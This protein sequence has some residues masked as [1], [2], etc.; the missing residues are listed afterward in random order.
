MTL[1]VKNDEVLWV[2]R[3]RPLKI[4]DTILPEQTKTIF[5]KFVEDQ[6]IPNLLLAGGPGMGKTTVAKAM[7]NELGCDYIVKNGSLN[8]G[9]DVLRYEISSFASSMSLSGGRKYVIFDEADYLNAANVQPALRNFIEEYSKNCGFIFTCNFKNRLIEPL[10][11][12]LS[13]VDFSIEKSDKPKLAMQFYK[14]VIAIL[15]N[16][17]VQHDPKVIAKVIE[18]HFPDFR[19]ILTEL[20]SYSAAGRIDEGIFANIKQESIDTLFE[21]LKSKKWTDM[22]KWC[23]DNS[24]Q[25]S[26]ELFRRIY[27]ASTDKIELKS[28]PG[29][30]VT[31]AD[32][33]Y[34]ANFVA[35]P[36]INMIAFLTELMMETSFR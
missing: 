34:K 22:R 24:D 30:A 15:N 21:L 29:F 7:L 28:M 5:K 3:Y 31:L 25:D 23:A 17:N 18:K 20:Q 26:N 11:S 12:R 32:Y 36:E 35:D 1:E 19:R 10:R 2:E 16:E 33:M 27:D 4:E 9:I 14:R 6:S 13:E 8:V